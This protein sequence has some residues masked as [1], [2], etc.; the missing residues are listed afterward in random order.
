V[1]LGSEVVH[2]AEWLAGRLFHRRITS[3]APVAPTP[4]TAPRR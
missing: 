3:V 2:E 1:L 4:A